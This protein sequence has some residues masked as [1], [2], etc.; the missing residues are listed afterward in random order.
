MNKKIR[1]KNNNI[2]YIVEIK[3]NF[4]KKK[5]QTV[6]KSKNK[7]FIIVDNKISFLTNHL[8]KKKNVYLIKVKG[9][10]KI[11]SFKNYELL[12]NKI[13]KKG[14]D[15]KSTIVSIGGGTVGDLS[16]YIAST[17][18]RGVK[19]I[20]I[21]TTLLSQV[22]SSIGGKTGINSKFG[23]NLIG[24][25][26]QP[27]EVFI[28]PKILET[29]PV[30]QLKSGYAEI[31]KHSIINDYTF[32]NWLDKN[33]KEIF[34]LAK[35]EISYAIYK[36]IKIKAKYVIED[37]KETLINNR[38]RAMLN[39]GH[40]FGHALETLYQYKKNITHGEAI[41]I[42]MVTASQISHHLSSLSLQQL[43]MIIN[44]LNKVSLPTYDKNIKNKKIFDIMKK[45]KKNEGKR[46]NLILI[47]KIGKAFYSR[48]VNLNKIIKILN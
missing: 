32:F 2:N 46:F 10:E 44:H 19:H 15:R 18:L 8:N 3:F 20:L 9:S 12:V 41:S 25:F 37:T 33:Y 29:L 5:L 26:Y 21:P 34:K 38:S 24:T 30:R 40:T 17:I 43:N 13:L 45:D 47:K 11:K 35:K 23:K 22:D 31:I 36:S 48:D 14:I 1:I 6:T 28:D 16:G 42:G 39:F 4:F 7:V 27:S